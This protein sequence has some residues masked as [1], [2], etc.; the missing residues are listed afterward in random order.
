MLSVKLPETLEVEPVTN[1]VTVA[2]LV[3]LPVSTS[4]KSSEP[5]WERN[6]TVHIGYGFTP[7]EVLTETAQVPMVG[8]TSNA[9]L[10]SEAEAFCGIADELEPSSLIMTKLLESKLKRAIS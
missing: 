1:R 7:L 2:E 3:L 10:I 4:T 5:N 8:T 6:V 9:A